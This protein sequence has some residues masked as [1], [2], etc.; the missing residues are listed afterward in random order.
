MTPDARKLILAGLATV[1]LVGCSFAVAS[2]GSASREQV[3]K[4]ADE[5]RTRVN[6]YCDAR[7]KALEA[8]GTG[9]A[10]ARQ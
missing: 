6:A 8:L 1:V 9:E 4:A 5:A 2:C 10:G 7:A 3:E